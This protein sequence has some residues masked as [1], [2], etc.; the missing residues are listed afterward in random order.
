MQK[1]VFSIIPALLISLLMGACSK[2][3]S[4]QIQVQYL[5]HDF[6][7]QTVSS[8]FP[9]IDVTF[10]TDCADQL[11]KVTC[12]SDQED[13]E[14]DVNCSVK[15]VTPEQLAALSKVVA[16]LPPLHRKMMCTLSRI[17]I[18][19]KI[20]SM[21]YA[22]RVVSA[23]PDNKWL[24]SMIGLR[25][26]ILKKHAP[27]R[28]LNSWKEQLNFGLSKMKDPN[29][30]VS[31]LGPTI[32]EETPQTQIS[33]LFV[34]VHELN[35]LFDM[36]NRANDRHPDFDT[37]VEDEKDKKLFH[38]KSAVDS[39]SRLSWGD[40]LDVIA[41]DPEEEKESQDTTQ[42]Y[43]RPTP[44]WAEKFP[45]VSQLCFYDCKK[46]ISPLLIKQVYQEL[47]NTDFITSYSASNYFEDFAEAGTIWA[48]ENY[49]IPYIY[50]IKGPD[51][52]VYFDATKQFRSPNFQAKKEWLDK[53][54]ARE[55]LIYSPLERE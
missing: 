46:T 38:C 52:K 45:L 30:K 35:H 27:D 44:S 32:Q 6:I 34:F 51:K 24:G 14:F 15:R 23:E 39:Y 40:S 5:S 10:E 7:S 31:P 42:E 12:V 53:F 41:Y 22:G 55:N 47:N 36:L 3:S 17:Q 16:D 21:A 49:K 8:D 43:Q 18:Q 19:D 9:A 37:C 29:L 4:S 33:Y 26:D 48:F 25:S 2:S 20:F 1:M 28:D 13:L 50:Q 54:F 11:R